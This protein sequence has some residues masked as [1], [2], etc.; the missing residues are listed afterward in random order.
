MNRKRER[1]DVYAIQSGKILWTLTN[2]SSY[3]NRIYMQHEDHSKAMFAHLDEIFVKDGEE[4]VEGQLIGKIGN[5]G[6]S[7]NDS[8]KHLHVSYFSK[9]ARGYSSKDTQDATF[10]IKLHTY[11][12]NTIITN[13]YRS[14]MYNKTIK[15]KDGTPKLKFHEG[16]D[17]SY[18]HLIEG[19]ENGVDALYQDYLLKSKYPEYYD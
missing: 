1:D 16:V 14:N 5:S 13:P 8:G 19:Y 10:W 7:L 17:F 3:G 12:T 9:R 2:E 6:Y 15:N 4:V 11:P 18:E